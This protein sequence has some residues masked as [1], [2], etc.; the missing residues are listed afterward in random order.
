MH[1]QLAET[2]FFPSP[3]EAVPRISALLRQEDFK[4]L[5]TYY[6]LSDSNLP[7]AQLESGAFFIR[8]ERP[9]VAHPAGFWRYKHPFAPG[10]EYRGMRASSRAH[11]FVISVEISI[12][13]GAGSPSQV[14]RSS[15]YMI[16]SG[17]GWQLLPDPVAENEERD[18]P[19]P[20]RAD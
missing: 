8:D 4:T 6:D 18:L 14:G 9:E 7:P 13:Q 3:E 2:N 20:E 5:A 11:V 16:Q 12:D 10:F 19:L 15:F 1:D 17:K